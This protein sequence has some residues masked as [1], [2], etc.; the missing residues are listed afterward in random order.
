[1]TCQHTSSTSDVKPA[2]GPRSDLSVRLKTSKSISK[3]IFDKAGSKR[4][5]LDSSRINASVMCQ[6]M[7]SVV[8]Y[9]GIL[10]MQDEIR[11]FKR[12]N[13]RD[14]SRTSRGGSR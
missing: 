8:D 2:G 4:P 3:Q 5:L 1:M 7:M 14:E 13:R 11:L 6:P 12:A 9:K 10:S